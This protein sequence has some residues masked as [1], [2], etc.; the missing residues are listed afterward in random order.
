MRTIPLY[1]QI[2][3]AI[4]PAFVAGGLSGPDTEVLGVSTLA[5]FDF[6]GTLF[7]NALR[8]LIVPLV[9]SSII[10]GIAGMGNTAAL[11]RIGGKTLAFY[12]ISSLMAIL[13]G[14]AAVN[15]MKPGYIDGQPAGDRLSLVSAEEVQSEI[16]RAG[17]QDAG[18]IVGIFLRLV[19]L[20]IIE[21]AAQEQMLG[22]I[23]FGLLFGVFM[24]RIEARYQETLLNFWQAVFQTMMAMT[25]FV[26]KFAPIGVFGLVAET[27]A[28]TGF[29]ALRIMAWFFLTVV[30]ALAFHTLVIMSLVL[31]Y[32]G[33][34]NPLKHYRAMAPALLTA[35]STASSSGTL[36][37]TIKCAE[38]NAGIS[39]RTSSFVLPL[40]ATINMDGTALYECVAVIFIAQAYG[41]DLTFADQFTVVIIAL[42][43]SIGVA[44]IPA[45]SLV[46]IMVIMTV[47]Q[48]PLELVGLLMV[49]D[50]ILDMMR[51]TVNVFSDTCCAAVVARSEGEETKLTGPLRA[52]G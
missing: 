23:V 7:L 3:I 25:M 50:R 10:C 28:K 51:T 48:L 18:D 45:A 39:N 35:F 17:D 20:N 14:L 1:W 36:P 15:L 37:L 31:K 32:V 40:G 11:G 30:L 47:L 34:V 16:A 12:M 27:I 2:I 22:I 13:V 43:T 38:E 46:A 24:T 29:E 6:I 26:M 8:M 5:V 4:L 49:T 42:L 33:R 21:A 9:L 44:G 19:P 41:A 52:T